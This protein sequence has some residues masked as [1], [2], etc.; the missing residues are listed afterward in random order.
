MSQNTPGKRFHK[1]I[2]ISELF[3][4]FPDDKTA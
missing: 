1:G 3:K 2:T 4:M